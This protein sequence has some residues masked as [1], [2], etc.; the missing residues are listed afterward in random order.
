MTD[1]SMH[2]M[3]KFLCAIIALTNGKPENFRK[4]PETLESI[5]SE[6][7]VTNNSK[8]IPIDV[9]DV[10]IRR[11]HLAVPDPTTALDDRRLAISC[12]RSFEP[13]CDMYSYVRF[14]NKRFKETDCY[15]SPA[16]HPLGIDAPPIEAKYVVFQPDRVGTCALI[17]LPYMC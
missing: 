1:S 13:T 15:R 17:L 11:R 14:W 7:N 9:I 3:T 10:I 6:K 2:V 5:I 4:M 16:R 8:S 12:K